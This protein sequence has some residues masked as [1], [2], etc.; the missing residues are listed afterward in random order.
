MH[1]SCVLVCVRENMLVC[2]TCLDEQHESREMRASTS[3]SP[4]LPYLDTG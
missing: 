4:P 1:F 3:K 2:G